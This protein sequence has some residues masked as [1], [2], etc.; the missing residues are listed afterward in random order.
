MTFIPYASQT[1]TTESDNGT[2][3]CY[4][5]VDALGN[6]S[7]SL[8]SAIAG[9][10]TSAPTVVMS[11]TL[12]DPT[13][14][15]PIPVTVTFSESVTGFTASDILAVNGTV[16]NF[17][18][19]GAAYTFD[20]TPSANGLVTANIAAGVAIDAAGNGNRRRP[21]QPH[22]RYYCDHLSLYILLPIY[23]EIKCIRLNMCESPSSIKPPGYR[24]AFSNRNIV[25]V[26]GQMNWP[27]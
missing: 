7:Y 22:L 16:S 19:S 24:A 11:S 2:R 12:G 3:V 20:L 26:Y 10:D 5:A 1:F 18:G 4:K 13:N 15:T 17:A 25:A 23:R 6:T 21:I 9:I 27:T 14:T 8:S